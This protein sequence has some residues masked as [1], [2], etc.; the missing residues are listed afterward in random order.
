MPRLRPSKPAESLFSPPPEETPE[1]PVEP[2]DANQTSFAATSSLFPRDSLSF[3][4]RESLSPSLPISPQISPR[5]SPE[6]SLPHNPK[7]PATRRVSLGLPLD[8]AD[9]L[10]PL[11][12]APAAAPPCAL[13]D[14]CLDLLRDLPRGD[15]EKT[16]Q[17]C[18]ALVAAALDAP[19]PADAAWLPAGDAASVRAA[20]ETWIPAVARA[21]SVLEAPRLPAGIHLSQSLLNALCAVFSPR[22]E[23]GARGSGA[24]RSI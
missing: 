13:A 11:H 6:P 22:E 12:D 23:V 14:A 7:I 19:R 15:L 24:R 5:E 1:K 21:L 18:D 9:L 20:A 3:S 10:V 2:E 16:A 17:A 8:P 4:P